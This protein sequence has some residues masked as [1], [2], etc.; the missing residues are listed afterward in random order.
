MALIFLLCLHGL[1]ARA[2]A[3]PLHNFFLFPYTTHFTNYKKF[4][5]ITID[6]QIQYGK[7]RNGSVTGSFQVV[8]RRHGQ[9]LW[10]PHGDGRATRRLA[11]LPGL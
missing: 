8:A 2:T 6:V 1:E 5:F 7:T 10:T 11:L 3:D 4:K 9:V